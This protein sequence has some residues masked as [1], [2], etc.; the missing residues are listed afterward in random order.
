MKYGAALDAEFFAFLE[1]NADAI[2]QRNEDV[3]TEVVTRCCRLKADIVERDER[4]TN[5]VYGPR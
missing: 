3:L 2:I 5:P 4:E 1:Q